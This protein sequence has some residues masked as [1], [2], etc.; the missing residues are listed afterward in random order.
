MISS[1]IDEQQT[2]D[3]C[4]VKNAM[5]VTADAVDPVSSVGGQRWD[6]AV[7]RFVGCTPFHSS[8]WARVLASTYG[9]VPRY[10]LLRMGGEVAACIPVMEVS[11]NWTGRRGVSLPFSD[12]CGPLVKAFGVSKGGDLREAVTQRFVDLSAYHRWKYCEIRGGDIAMEGKVSASPSEGSTFVGHVLTLDEPY[13]A[14]ESHFSGAARRGVRKAAAAGLRVSISSDSSSSPGP[15]IRRSHSAAVEAYYYLH[16]R[17]RRR[18]GLP[19]QS[20]T[21]FRRVIAEMTSKESGFVML[22][23]TPSGDPVAGAVFFEFRGSAVFKFGASLSDSWGGRPN[24][25]VMAEAIR[26][27]TERGVRTLHFGRT[28]LANQGLRR[29][30]LGWGAKEIPLPYF[31]V[32]PSS[33]SPSSPIATDESVGVSSRS[34][35]HLRSQHSLQRWEITAVREAGVS[36]DFGLTLRRLCKSCLQRFPLFAHRIAGRFMY[37]HLD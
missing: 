10:S 25:L 16:Q 24:N 33:K 2:D 35:T 36:S 9:H 8:A 12:L 20:L 34:A 23:E 28:E 30:K 26:F 13:E 32:H 18:H 3:G 31:R 11:S 15:Y 4:S 27:L 19:P 7:S 1:V 21:F 14:T 22:A 37:P 6:D 17:T 5:T 29:F